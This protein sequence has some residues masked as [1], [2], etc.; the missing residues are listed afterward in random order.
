[1]CACKLISAGAK[2]VP[3]IQ[4]QFHCCH[5]YSSVHAH[6]QY[7]KLLTMQ[8]AAFCT[9]GE[10]KPQSGLASM[11]CTCTPCAAHSPFTGTMYPAYHYHPA[12]GLS[13]FIRRS[14]CICQLSVPLSTNTFSFLHHPWVLQISYVM[15]IWVSGKSSSL[16]A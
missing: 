12:C 14:W 6:L 7:I 2:H 13:N 9:K 16:C 5:L 3:Q 15:Q 4:A 1:M 11:G 10:S 8:G